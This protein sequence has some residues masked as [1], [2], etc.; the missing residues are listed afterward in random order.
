MYGGCPVWRQQV[1][2]HVPDALK[3]D[4]VEFVTVGAPE[5]DHVEQHLMPEL[6]DFARA[7][8]VRSN[9]AGLNGRSAS[10]LVISMLASNIRQAHRLNVYLPVRFEETSESSN[11]QWCT[12]VCVCVCVLK[13]VLLWATH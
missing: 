7:F 3:T 13:L 8:F 11:A 10:C 4:C 12:Y 2:A 1:W 9:E 5:R 6:Q